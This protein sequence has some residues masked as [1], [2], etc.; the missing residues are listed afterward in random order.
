MQ[1]SRNTLQLT[2]IQIKQFRC[3][4]G[5]TITFAA[6]IVLVQGNNGSGKTS[7]LEALHYL[8]YL[9]SFRTHS[10]RDLI[11]SGADGFFIKALFDQSIEGQSLT[12]EVQVG[13]SGKKRL[14]KMNQQAVISYKELID[15]YR[16]ITLTEDDLQLINLGPD[17]RRAFIDQAILLHEPDFITTLKAYKNSMENRN[18]LLML[19]GRDKDSYDVWTQQMWEKACMIQERRQSLLHKIQQ[20]VNELLAHHFAAE[21]LS[22]EFGY[23]AKKMGQSSFEEFLGENADLYA[24]EVRFGR[25]LFGAHLDD[26]T[27]KFQNR[28]SKN[29][30]SRGQQKLIIVLI[31]IAQIKQLGA[32][33]G[34]A[35]FLLDDFMTDFDIPRA[36]TLMGILNGLES[37]LIFTSPIA[38]GAFEQSLVEQGAQ[39]INLTI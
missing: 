17:V 26:F 7:L 11:R 6:P 10:P 37:Q 3:F 20:E 9:R 34:P 23:G 30:A 18:K 19:G 35:V 38:Q 28:K 1:G 12:H 21:A 2:S 24:Q 16:I 33:K 36:Q 5:T 8:C 27:I 32:L 14:V 39:R 15:H 22:I 31:K 29:F 13:F 25:S 4:E